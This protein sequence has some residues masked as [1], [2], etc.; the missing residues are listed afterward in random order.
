MSVGEGKTIYASIDVPECRVQLNDKCQTVWTEGDEI[1]VMNQ[2][3][4]SKY[5]FDGKT[6]DLSGSFTKVASGDIP[7]EGY[8]FDK[9]YAIYSTESWYGY[10]CF[11]DG[12]PAMFARVLATQTYMK[13]SYG[14]HANFMFG[15]SED[16]ANYSFRNLFGYLRLSMVGSKKISKISLIGNDREIIAGTLYFS[17]RD[18]LA[19]TWYD[20]MSSLITLDCGEGVTLSETPTSFYLVL[21]P[22]TFEKGISVCVDFADGTNYIHTT[23]KSIT[24]E[25]NV[26]QPMATFN[27][28]INDD[29]YS[30]LV[31]HHTGRYID[32]PRFNGAVSGEVDWGDGKTSFLT[33]FLSYD[34]T[35]DVASH[36]VTF[37]VLG[38]KSFELDSCE[39]ISSID[40]SNF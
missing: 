2:E 8:V 17:V 18:Y 9:S 21:P 28:D 36:V 15:S 24:I 20:G 34:F 6:G 3:E 16:G 10:G 13:D 31:L 30:R 11:S 38:A 5:R 1:I 27:V 12:T 4:Y 35:D 29:N 26:I 22:V 39:G 37:K 32:M 40:L 14:L 7:P 25:R 33:D 23:G 19:L